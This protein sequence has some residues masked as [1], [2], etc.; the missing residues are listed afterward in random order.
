MRDGALER[1]AYADCDR[2]L[3]LAS[4]ANQAL[5]VDLD[6][7][8]AEMVALRQTA[9]RLNGELDDSL[10]QARADREQLHEATEQLHAA[11]A[12]IAQLTAMIGLLTERAATAAGET[13]TL[14]QHR[15]EAERLRQSSSWRITRP[16]RA[17]VRPTRTLRTLFRRGL[18]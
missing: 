6:R 5:Q 11:T 1:Q 9:I 4:H 3:R 10:R 12:Q 7:S 13:A 16:L 14:L 18:D 2:A 15:D 17:V 8:I